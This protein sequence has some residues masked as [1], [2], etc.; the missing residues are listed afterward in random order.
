MSMVKQRSKREDFLVFTGSTI[1]KEKAGGQVGVR[2]LFWSQILL[3]NRIYLFFTKFS[4]R[5]MYG[6]ITAM[7]YSRVFVT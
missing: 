3:L 4:D 1:L 2:L 6:Y 7:K 5:I